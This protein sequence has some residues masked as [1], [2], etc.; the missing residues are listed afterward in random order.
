LPALEQN[1]CVGIVA[2]RSRVPAHHIENAPTAILLTLRKPGL[3]REYLAAHHL[4]HV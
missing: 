2:V 4:T 3:Q 1:R